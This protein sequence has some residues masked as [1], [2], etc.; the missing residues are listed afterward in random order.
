MLQP[1]VGYGA[2][3]CQMG[4]LFVRTLQLHPRVV[5]VVVLGV[6]VSRLKCFLVPHVFVRLLCQVCLQ[7][8]AVPV[9]CCP[10][11]PPEGQRQTEIT[12][13]CIQHLACSRTIHCL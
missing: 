1:A 3:L 4:R 10:P 5:F 13:C 9:A 2:R 8:L 11:A 12:S 6:A 7:Q